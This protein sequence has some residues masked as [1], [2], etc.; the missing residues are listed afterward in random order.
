MLLLLRM[1]TAYLQK[2]PWLLAG[3]AHP[4]IQIS[5]EIGAKILQ[6]WDLDP[7]PEAHHRITSRLLSPGAFLDSLKAWVAGANFRD[8]SE[9]Y[10]KH[11][12]SLRFTPIVETTIEEKHARV[13]MSKK[14][15]HLGPVRIS[16]ANRLPLLERWIKRGHVSGKQLLD[17]FTE[18]RQ[19]KKV[20]MLLRVE[21][22]PLLVERF[23]CRPGKMRVML[24]KVLYHCDLQNMHESHDSFGRENERF[25]RKAQAQQQKLVGRSVAGALAY[26]GVLRSAMQQHMLVAHDDTDKICLYSCSAASLCLQSVA[27]ALDEPE[28]KK[29]RL[30][31]EEDA[32]EMLPDV[33]LCERPASSITFQVVM[34]NPNDK[35][36][37]RPSVGAGGRLVKGAVVVAHKSFCSS[38]ALTDDT[39]LVS[40]APSTVEDIS[41]QF[42]L[43]GLSGSVEDL[44]TCMRKWGSTELAWTFRGSQSYGHAHGELHGLLR[45]MVEASAFVTHEE[46]LGYSA[47]PEEVSILQGL[48]QHGLVAAAGH[49]DVRWSFTELGTKELTSC[50]RLSA[51]SRV[52]QLREGIPLQDKTTYELMMSLQEEGW[53]W[54]RWVPP[55]KRTRRMAIMGRTFDAYCR[56]GQKVWYSTDVPSNSYMA[57]LLQAENFFD[58]GLPAIEHGREE[59]C[60][61]A[62]LR[63]DIQ[64][65]LAQLADLPAEID[66]LADGPANG[67]ADVPVADVGVS[68]AQEDAG[69]NVD[70]LFA[71]DENDIE[72]S[73]QDNDS[74]LEDLQECMRDFDEPMPPSPA[75]REAPELVESND[76]LRDEGDA[77][78]GPARGPQREPAPAAADAL[79]VEGGFFGFFRVTA[80]RP[81]S[82]GGGRYGGLQATCP[83]HKKNEKTGCK[84]F[85]ALEDG[86]EST[87]Q[88][89]MRRLAWW[90]TMAPDFNRQRLHL[91]APLPLESCP[92][93]N[94]LNAKVALMVEPDAASVRSDIEL[95]LAAA[96]AAPA[97]RVAAA[98][99][100]KGKAK[101]K[102]KAKAKGKAAVKPKP[103][104][105]GK[106]KPK[107]KAKASV[108]SNSSDGDGDSLMDAEI[109]DPSGLSESSTDSSSS[110]SSDSSS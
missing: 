33:D 16:L 19:L 44:Q 26:D 27:G 29:Q 41:G 63:G 79:D 97:A 38:D 24:A 98:P 65:Q 21:G 107:A 10:Q 91:S 13:A 74:L 95:A 15:H 103:K 2:L 39:V 23:G 78:P 81:G 40:G 50:L 7:R 37:I 45:G 1:K 58:M 86:S 35:K 104:S 102:A 55:S 49:E 96:P 14:R 6:Q 5:R 83:F 43:S 99:V 56:D 73:D 57:V 31:D 32:A 42:L 61:K 75:G 34:K 62:I 9:E 59:S 28:T 94:V 12:A 64:S 52:F 106:A 11:V 108:A 30:I 22:H 20:P 110:S 67:P 51:P 47:L 46:S 77:L 68:Q 54:Q 17:L 85:L 90:C 18:S 92:P 87:K 93:W 76:E 3:L 60:Y 100:P 72:P 4:D 25:K 53:E 80:K 69:E 70:A 101:A 84:R 8:L 48:E 89:T 88:D 36:V 105:K 109:S 71:A 66:A 82:S